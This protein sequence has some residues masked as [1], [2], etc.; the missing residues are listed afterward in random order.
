MV[1]IVIVNYNVEKLLEDCKLD[2]ALGTLV[3][4]AL[5]ASSNNN[6]FLEVKLKFLFIV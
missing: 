2:H 4:F 1:G 3:S 5:T 6:L